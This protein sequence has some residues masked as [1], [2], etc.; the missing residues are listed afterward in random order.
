MKLRYPRAWLALVP[1]LALSAP[2]WGQRAQQTF[3][4]DAGWNSV[5][6]EVGAAPE[7][8]DDVFAGKP[9]VSVWMRSNEVVTPVDPECEGANPP[10]DCLAE[11]DTRW[12]VWLPPSNPSAE[13]VT[14]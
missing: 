4:L 8:A 7:Q 3:S 14:S 5:F 11:P 1:A 13:A 2:A 6:I 9:I 10:D 12:R